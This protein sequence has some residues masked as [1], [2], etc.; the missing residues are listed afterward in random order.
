MREFISNLHSDSKLFIADYDL[1][2]LKNTKLLQKV[3]CM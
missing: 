3:F 1:T 2:R